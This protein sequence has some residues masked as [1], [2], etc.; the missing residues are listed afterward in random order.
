MQQ[1]ITTSTLASVA[2]I[3]QEFHQLDPDTTIRTVRNVPAAIITDLLNQVQIGVEKP[4]VT[5]TNVGRFE[6]VFRKARKYK[7]IDR[8]TNQKVERIADAH[9][10][11][12]FKFAPVWNELVASH[13][14]IKE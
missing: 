2:N 11:V 14:D 3:L 1:E 9:Y 8:K 7:L 5:I 10:A 13:F 6:L 4:H 12:K